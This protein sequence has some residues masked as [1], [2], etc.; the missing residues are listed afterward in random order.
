MRTVVSL[1]LL[2]QFWTYLQFKF[3]ISPG[4][5]LGGI[6]DG[7]QSPELYLYLVQELAKLDLAYLHVMHLG[8]EKLLQDVRSIWTNPLLV[9]RAEPAL[10]DLSTDLDNGIADI[11]PVGAWSL[12]NLDLVERLKTRAPLNEADP[13]TFFAVGS[14]GYTDYPTLKELE[15]QRS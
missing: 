8:N 4:T 6:Q 12:A 11:V 7:E 1:C 2:L 14:K 13:K 5:P 15:A 3:C 9:N 10:E